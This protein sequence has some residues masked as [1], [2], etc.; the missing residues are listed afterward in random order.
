MKIRP[1][2]E[3]HYCVVFL[4]GV[5]LCASFLIFIATNSLVVFAILFCLGAFLT[6]RFW[7]AFGRCIDM[8]SSGLIVSFLF[9]KKR[10][11]WEN[12]WQVKVFNASNCIGYKSTLSCGVEVFF[13]TASRP[14][15][16]DP[17]AYCFFFNTA[18]YVF[19]SF[20]GTAIQPNGMQYPV[21]YE[22]SESDLMEKLREWGVKTD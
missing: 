2:K 3:I 22:V 9:F 6:V 11:S 8:D 20:L 16:L 17:A 19:L 4:L 18:N 13:H 5:S 15:W 10:I 1:E 21:Y 14:A 12:V 7:F